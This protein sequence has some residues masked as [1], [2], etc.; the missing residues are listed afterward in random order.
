MQAL[1]WSISFPD[2]LR[3]C[4]CIAAAANLTAQ[5]LGFEVIGRNMIVRDPNFHAGDY[6]GTDTQP[7]NGLGYARMIGHLT[8]L[9]AI[10]MHEKFGRNKRETFDPSNFETGFEVE[11]YLKHQGKQFVTRFDANSYLHI[12]Y[13]MDQFDLESRYGSL[14][15][16]F[17]EAQA[18]FLLVALSSDWLFP[19]EQTRELGKTLLGLKK[20]AS[21]AELHSPHG[22]DAFL[23][24]VEHL[25]RVI[26]G[27]LE[28]PSA[29]SARPATP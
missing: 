1:Q 14:E 17:R 13:A 5:A 29:S 9:S 19:P 2:K 10:S 25:S 20:V 23:L 16:A 22:H 21:V 7:D 26:N 18:E 8:Y 3:K 15:N 28:K 4:L 24:E 12:T 6:Y 11:S 27:F